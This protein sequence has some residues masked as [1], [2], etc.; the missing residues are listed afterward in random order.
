MRE[1]ETLLLEINTS[2]A[3]RRPRRPELLRTSRTTGEP[4]RELWGSAVRRTSQ[5]VT[6]LTSDT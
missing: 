4:T 6:R 5:R 1:C 2:I 3:G